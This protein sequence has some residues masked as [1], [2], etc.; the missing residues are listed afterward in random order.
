[1][2]PSEETYSEYVKSYEDCIL[3]VNGCLALSQEF[4]G[5]PAPTSA[6]YWASVLFTKLCV[7]ALTIQSICPDPTKLGNNARWDCT[8]VAS[9]TRGL[10][11]GY[12][13]FHYLCVD[14]CDPEEWQARWRLLN[15][16]DH[17][18]RLKMFRALDDATSNASGQTAQFKAAAEEVKSDLAANLYFKSLTDKLQKHYL[19]GAHPFFMSKDEIVESAG[20][21]INEFRYMY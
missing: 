14:E 17:M 15:L 20:L 16:H 21:D 3:V 6:H 18:S 4:G 1:M 10:V 8:S 19:Q 7:S 5:T 11:E 9:L 12:L 2:V 13:V